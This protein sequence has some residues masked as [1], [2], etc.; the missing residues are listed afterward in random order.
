[1][2]LFPENT[3]TDY[4]QIPSQGQKVKHLGLAWNFFLCIYHMQ[5]RKNGTTS[6][7]TILEIMGQSEHSTPDNHNSTIFD[8]IQQ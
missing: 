6:D 5:P 3:G 8:T 7:E 2:Q 4:I 1:M